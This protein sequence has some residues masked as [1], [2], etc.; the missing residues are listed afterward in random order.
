MENLRLVLFVSLSFVSFLLW[1]AW[2]QD[3][4]PRAT[5]EL[6]APPPFATQAPPPVDVP[7]VTSSDTFDNAPQV[8]QEPTADAARVSVVTDVFSAGISLRGGTLVEAALLRFP[9]AAERP[10][11][12]FLLLAQQDNRF[13]ISQG[14]ILSDAPAPTHLDDFSAE[15]LSYVL[16]ED[17]DIVD[18][19]LRWQ[20]PAGVR[21]TK[22]FRFRRG[23]YL[24][25]TRYDIE[26]T[27]S[28]DWTGRLYTQ[29]QREGDAK[30]D[31]F[32]YTF[33]GVALSTPE[34]RYEKFDREDLVDQPLD[35]DI[36]SG[37]AAIIEHYFVAAIVPDPTLVYHYYSKTIGD[38]RYVVGMYAPPVAVQP[39]STATLSIRNYVGPKTQS[40]LKTTAPSLELTVDYGV[41][42]FIAKP[43]YFVLDWIHGVTGNWGWAIILLTCLV[44][45][46]F[47]HLSAMGYRSMAQMRRVQPRM[48]AMRERYANDKA[49]LNQAMMKL[50][51]EEKI[52]PL[53]G[54]FPI[55]V[56]I[57][58]FLAL[59]WVLL[60]SVEL[61]QA[62]FVLWLQDLSSRDPYF[63]L[64]LI[65]GVSMFIQQKLNP[66][67]MDPMQEKIMQ[68]L[69][70]VFTVFFAFFPSG[71]VLYWVVNNILSIAQ[72]W[73]I[74]RQIETA[75]SASG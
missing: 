18:V 37:W 74:T 39:G 57:P 52:N 49:R 63:V 21:F 14:G 10:E 71:L 41:L 56:Q 44:K 53:G 2:Q 55:L 9:L 25:E 22:T 46:L 72:Q 23:S 3:Y 75:A 29:L 17:Q 70:F 28:A 11:D 7:R 69:P 8:T 6:P 4:G 24:I 62:S 5:Q 32:V 40:V 35:A 31:G 58:V 66:A 73:V 20:S 68:L 16:T 64:P 50:Y 54:C 67:P 27:G 33:T 30:R 13:F 42:W 59:Y 45:G 1:Q 19:P 26:N 60:E 15:R 38:D 34:K 48:M 65:M 47:F 12:P 51:K 43:L 36:Q 61:R